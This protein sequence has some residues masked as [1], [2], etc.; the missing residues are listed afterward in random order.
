MVAEVVLTG[1]VVAVVMAK[2]A[3]WR[4]SGTVAEVVVE[5]LVVGW[6]RSWAAWYSKNGTAGSKNGTAG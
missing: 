2:A 5:A 4:F 1:V 6:E 3:G